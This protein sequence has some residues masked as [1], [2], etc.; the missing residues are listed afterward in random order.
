[1][2][3]DDKWSI[4]YSTSWTQSYSNWNQPISSTNSQ[5]AVIEAIDNIVQ[6]MVVYPD[7]EKLLEDIRL[8]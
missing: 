7:A 5:L 6:H 8:K 4:S 3:E 2:N 1:M